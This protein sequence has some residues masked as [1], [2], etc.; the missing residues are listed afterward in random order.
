MGRLFDDVIGSFAEFERETIVE[1]VNA[2]LDAARV[3]GALCRPE[4][5]KTAPK[6]I[7]ALREEGLSHRQIAA[8]EKPSAPSAFKIL[9]GSECKVGAA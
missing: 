6:R 5:D 8:K 4:K 7:L 1:R 9:K 2:G 3:R